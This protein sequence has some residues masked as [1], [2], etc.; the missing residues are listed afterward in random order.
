[1]IS[2]NHKYAKMID[3]L[4]FTF[5]YLEYFFFIIWC[6]ILRFFEFITDY[7]YLNMSFIGDLFQK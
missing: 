1:M 2:K 6:S 7:L 3:D 5:R 4:V